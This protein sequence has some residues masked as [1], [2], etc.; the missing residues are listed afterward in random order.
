MD[1]ISENEVGGIVCDGFGR[2]ADKNPLEGDYEAHDQ[3]EEDYDLSDARLLAIKSSIEVVVLA[4]NGGIPNDAED[5][6]DVCRDVGDKAGKFETIKY[7]SDRE[8][9]MH[10]AVKEVEEL[11][12]GGKE[13]CPREMDHQ[14]SRKT[15]RWTYVVKKQSERP[16]EA[17]LTDCDEKEGGKKPKRSECEK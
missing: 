10:W 7:W 1:A 8:F 14:R 3:L 5:G 6:D 2:Q 11:Q 17:F 13:A 4:Q 16:P 12:L 15:G 9:M